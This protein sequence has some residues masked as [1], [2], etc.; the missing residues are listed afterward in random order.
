MPEEPDSIIVGIINIET[1]VTKDKVPQKESIISL[2]DENREKN[3]KFSLSDKNYELACDAYKDNKKIELTGILA[4]R[5]NAWWLDKP[6]N[7]KIKSKT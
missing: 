4:K 2:F 7:L 3:I 5:D 1:K 6:H